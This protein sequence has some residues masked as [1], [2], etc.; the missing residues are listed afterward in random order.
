MSSNALLLSLFLLLLCLFSEI[1]GS[2]TTHRKIENESLD[3]ERERPVKRAKWSQEADLQKLDVFEKLEAKSN[4]E[5]KE[6]K[7]EGED[8][9]EVEESQG[10]ESDN[11]DYDQN[12]DFDDDDDDY[13]QADDGDFEEVVR[14]G[15]KKSRNAN[16][17][18]LFLLLLCLFSEIEGI[19]T[20]RRRVEEPVRGRI[21]T[22]PSVTCGGQRLGGPQPSLSPCP[23]PQPR[24]RPGSLRRSTTD[25]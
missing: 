3:I 10:E 11:G 2:E 15:S 12:Q 14:M 20:T 18:S 7:E 22:P 24:S 6:E 1:G 9:E 17:P 5:G 23:R 25:P 13:N 16:L 21:A 19:Q 8:D 4:A